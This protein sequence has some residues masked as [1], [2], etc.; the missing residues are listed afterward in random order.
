MIRTSPSGS[1]LNGETKPAQIE[2][3]DKQ[4]ANTNR[5]LCI[6]LLVE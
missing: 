5:I 6:D 3:V 4:I 1:G 2:S